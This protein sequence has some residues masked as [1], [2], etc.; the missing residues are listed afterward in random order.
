MGRAYHPAQICWD[1]GRDYVGPGMLWNY[2]RKVLHTLL[3][4]ELWEEARITTTNSVLDQ[5]IH[6]FFNSRLAI[7]IFN[8]K[9]NSAFFFLKNNSV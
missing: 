6:L 3:L 9:N 2:G 7:Q 8:S 4:L 5:Q 1:A